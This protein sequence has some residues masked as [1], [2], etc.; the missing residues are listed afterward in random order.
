MN[1]DSIT[2]Q[3]KS[4]K[5]QW[6]NQLSIYREITWN[7][8]KINFHYWN[9]K[10]PRLNS[11]SL[12]RP[13][14]S[15]TEISLK[16]FFWKIPIY[17]GNFHLLLLRMANVKSISSDCRRF[18]LTIFLSQATIVAGLTSNVHRYLKIRDFNKLTRDN[19]LIISYLW[20]KSTLPASCKY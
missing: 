9:I 8:L 18:Q 1:L 5:F 7:Y 6:K 19:F 13:E 12:N 16:Q 15:G 3:R 2:F 20:G 4:W 10:N 17:S 14:N 11:E